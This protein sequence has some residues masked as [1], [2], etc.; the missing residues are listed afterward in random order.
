MKD[1]SGPLGDAA[2]AAMIAAAQ[3]GQLGAPAVLIYAIAPQNPP[4]GTGKPYVIL[5]QASLSPQ[6]AQ[7]IDG[8]IIDLVADIWSLTDPPGVREARAIASAVLDLMAPSTPGGVPSPPAW[9]LPGFVI[10]TAMPLAV[11]H[12]TD[13]ADQSAHSIVRVQYAVDPASPT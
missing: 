12:L 6:L 13:P 5:G 8:A 10:R 9:S 4:Q 7:C 2:E 3:A 11:D 1:P